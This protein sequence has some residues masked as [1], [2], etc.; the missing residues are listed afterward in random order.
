LRFPGSA[1]VC[2]R[3]RIRR[4][5]ALP[6]WQFVAARTPRESCPPEINGCSRRTTC[7]SG[8]GC[9]QLDRGFVPITCSHTLLGTHFSCMR[10]AHYLFTRRHSLVLSGSGLSEVPGTLGNKT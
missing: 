9:A 3:L 2:I 10:N 8:E 6:W 1:C 5:T 4:A 7:S